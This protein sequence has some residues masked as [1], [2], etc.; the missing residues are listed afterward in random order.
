MECPRRNWMMQRAPWD[1]RVLLEAADAANEPQAAA[2]VLTFLE[3]TK[4]QD[5]II[6]PLAQ[7]LRAQLK[8]GTSRAP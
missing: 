4:L 3:Q 5:P 1:A 7:Q 2:P 8:N 6:E